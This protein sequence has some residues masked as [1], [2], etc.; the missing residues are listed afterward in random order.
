MIGLY[1]DLEKRAAEGRPIRCGLI[2]SGQMGVDIVSQVSC[3]KGI[4]VSAIAD[5]ELARAAD[6]YRIAGVPQGRVASAKSATAA[7]EAVRGGRFVITDDPSLIPQIEALE[8]VVDATG[9][10]EAGAAIALDCFANGKHLVMMN[11]EAD[12]TIGPVLRR[13]AEQ[14]GV[15]YSLAAGDEPTALMELYG[16]AR[17]LGLEI[18]AAGKGKNNPLNHDA[19]PEEYAEEA[20]R[21]G[22]NPGMLVEFVDGSKT[23]V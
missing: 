12:A 5:L 17:A 7:M 8:S 22:L 19:A 3:M 18:V 11:V 15:I 4:E 10:P 9:Q 20:R 14:A 23:M 13:R 2:G 6:A 21:R 16:F 1:Q